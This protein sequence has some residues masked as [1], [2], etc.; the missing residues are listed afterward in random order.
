VSIRRGTQP[1]VRFP[2]SFRC[3]VRA[4]T[5]STFAGGGCTT[6]PPLTLSA[7]HLNSSAGTN[8][9][10]LPGV[11]LASCQRGVCLIDTCIPGLVLSDS[12]DG[13]LTSRIGLAADT[14]EENLPFC[15]ELEVDVAVDDDA[16]YT[17][18]DVVHFGPQ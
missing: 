7:T 13:C 12:F 14:D 16:E 2:E 9:L 8:C 17:V 18:V 5:V 10:S 4:L 6:P 3:C 1:T 11:Q 15:D